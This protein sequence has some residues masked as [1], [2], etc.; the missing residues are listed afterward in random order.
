MLAALGHFAHNWQNTA[1]LVRVWLQ[2]L[3]VLFSGF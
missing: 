1:G 3:L 2:S